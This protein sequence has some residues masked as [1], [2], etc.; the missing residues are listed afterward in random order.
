MAMVRAALI[1]ATQAVWLT[2]AVLASAAKA[3]LAQQQVII[4][5]VRE[6]NQYRFIFSDPPKKK[7][8]LC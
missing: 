4:R 5:V 6:S 1:A 2:A 3:K 8:E 7:R